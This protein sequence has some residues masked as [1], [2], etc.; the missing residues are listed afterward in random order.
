MSHDKSPEGLQ[1]PDGLWIG[2]HP[3]FEGISAWQ[4]VFWQQTQSGKTDEEAKAEVIRQ[5]EASD[6][7]QRKHEGQ[8]R[9]FS[10]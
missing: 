8:R 5:I 7:W 9:V 10:M 2:D 4:E 6:E 3:D 1:R